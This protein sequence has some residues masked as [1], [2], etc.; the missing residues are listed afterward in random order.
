M[1]SEYF[2]AIE[3][4]SKTLYLILGFIALCLFFVVLYFY[5]QRPKR[6]TIEWIRADHVGR[7]EPFTYEP[8]TY[9]DILFWLLTFTVTLGLCS[10]RFIIHYRLDLTEPFSQSVWQMVTTGAVATLALSISFFGFFKELLKACLCFSI[11]IYTYIAT[12]LSICE[13]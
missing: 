6:G 7:F 3:Q 2:H 5:V 12:I 1:P 9:K 13:L 8:L 11:V 4:S 10:L